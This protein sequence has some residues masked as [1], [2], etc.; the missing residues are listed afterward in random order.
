MFSGVRLNAAVGGVRGRVRILPPPPFDRLPRCPHRNKDS[1]FTVCS[2]LSKPIPLL[3]HRSSQPYPSDTVVGGV[4]VRVSILP[5]PPP[6]AGWQTMLPESVLME[7]VPPLHPD[8]RSQPQSTSPLN[9]QE[10]RFDAFHRMPLWL[11]F[12]SPLPPPGPPFDLRAGGAA[13]RAPRHRGLPGLHRA[14]LR[15]G[16]RAL[17]DSGSGGGW[18]G[19]TDNRGD[20][21]LAM[22]MKWSRERQIQ[23]PRELNTATMILPCHKNKFYVIV[24]SNTTTRRRLVVTFL[25]WSLFHNVGTKI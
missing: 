18:H 1:N 13:V 6:P 15:G 20:R 19:R 4:G 17:V 2:P 5:P 11:R 22:V 3:P 24:K 12:G 21:N 9:A 8:P 16:A 7:A 25:L 23:A 14:V 10:Q